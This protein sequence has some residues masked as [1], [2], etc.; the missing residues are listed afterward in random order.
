VDL[1]RSLCEGNEET[2][3]WFRTKIEAMV[4]Q[5]IITEDNKILLRMQSTITEYNDG[6]Q[7][8]GMEPDPEIGIAL[9]ALKYLRRE[10]KNMVK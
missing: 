5:F 9:A 10:A 1:W 3:T 6:Q 8:G 4:E 2:T 7:P